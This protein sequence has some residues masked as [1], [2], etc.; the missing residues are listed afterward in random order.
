M[1]KPNVAVFVFPGEEKREQALQNNL[2]FGNLVTVNI[3][4]ECTLLDLYICDFRE[5]R[6]D[7]EFLELI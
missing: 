4:L 1:Y 3:F 2:G 5:E 7:L 6:E